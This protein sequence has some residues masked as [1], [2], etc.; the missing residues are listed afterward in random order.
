MDS[1][2]SFFAV[3]YVVGASLIAAQ[4][5]Y[6]LVVEIENWSIPIASQETLACMVATVILQQNSSQIRRYE[7]TDIF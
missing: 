2:L 4:F 1:K 7:E 5:F 6:V 3:V